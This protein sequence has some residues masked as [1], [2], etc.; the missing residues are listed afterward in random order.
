MLNLP[1]LRDRADHET[2]ST[3][4][5]MIGGPYLVYKVT[6]S[7]EEIVKVRWVELAWIV[8]LVP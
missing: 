5:I 4:G 2:G 6:P 1:I 7:E 8:L 3:G